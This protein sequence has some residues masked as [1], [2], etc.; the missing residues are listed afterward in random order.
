MQAVIYKNYGPPSVL[1]IKDVVRPA[2]KDKELLIRVIATSVNRT[3]CAMLRAKPFI[4]RFFT[5]LFKPTKPILGTAFA[6]KVEAVGKDVDAFKIGEGVF[7]FDDTGVSS[8]AEYMTF[9]M[10]KAL[11]TIPD[12]ITFAQAAASSEGAHYAYN[13]INKVTIKKGDAI[14]VY[15]ATGAIGA[16]MVPLLKHLGAEV[17]A[18]CNTKNMDLVKSM[19]ADE[20]IDYTKGDFTKGARKYPFVFDAVG[21][22]SF[23]ICKP[24]LQPGGVY[25]SSE[26]GWMAQNIFFALFTPIFGGKKVI[27]PIPTNIK[28]SIEL[29]RQLMSEGKFNPVID[30]EYP[31]ERIAEAFD[32][33]ELGQ[34]TGNVVITVG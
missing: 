21:K 12:G 3:D 15:G 23:G 18:V 22:S 31:L 25:I 17:T 5:G 8:Y 1:S 9:P 32:Y 2:P 24:L 14:L 6:G 29:V 26:L 30:R 34:K 10:E 13:F 16:A 33:V 4:M 27:F 7:G 19:G 28:R 11:A 20:V